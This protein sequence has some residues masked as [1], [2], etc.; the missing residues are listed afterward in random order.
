ML[1]NVLLTVGVTL[2]LS[3]LISCG[4]DAPKS[5]TQVIKPVGNQMAYEQTEFT[6]PAGAE[7]TIVMDNIATMEAMK[8]NVVVV[9]SESLINEIGGAAISA[10]GYIPEHDG[11]IAATPMA[12]AQQKTEVTFT[13]PKKAGRYPYICTFPGHYVVMRGVMVVE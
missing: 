13:A 3:L 9:K 8:H 1:R 12:D 11:I 4:S 2:G 7:V 6:V 10:P 5:V